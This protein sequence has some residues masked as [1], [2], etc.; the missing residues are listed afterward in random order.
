MSEF[1]YPEEGD[2]VEIRLRGKI[3]SR[4]FFQKEFD[5]DSD[6]YGMYGVV[7]ATL[8]RDRRGYTYHDVYPEPGDNVKIEK[9]RPSA[10]ED[11]ASGDVYKVHSL[12]ALVTGTSG[13]DLEVVTCAGSRYS[14]EQFFELFPDYEKVT[15]GA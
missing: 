6:D 11:V 4:E 2:H 14:V 9:V 7:V 8:N 5:R 13:S 15:S 10:P 1:F 12:T 3:V